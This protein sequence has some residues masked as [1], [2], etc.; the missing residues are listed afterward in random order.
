[1]FYKFVKNL[2][3]VID[4]SGILR[5]KD[6]TTSWV[7]NDPENVDWKDYQSWSSAVDENGDLINQPLP[8]DEN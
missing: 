5:I 3:Q 7:P 4:E 6:G 2:N 8:P 1:M